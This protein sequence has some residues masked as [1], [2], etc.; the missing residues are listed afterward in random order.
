MFQRG[1]WVLV[2]FREGVGF[3]CISERVLVCFREAVECSLG[4]GVFQKGC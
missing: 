1:G 2:C 4:V 3:E